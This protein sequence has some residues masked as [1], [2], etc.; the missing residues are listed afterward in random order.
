MLILL[1]NIKTEKGPFI[2]NCTD[3]TRRNGFKLKKGEF[4]L[5]I[6]KKFLNLRVMRHWNRLLD[7]VV[8]FKSL[9]MFKAM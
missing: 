3:R 2:R 5:N 7:E 8:D 9:A 4:R 1:K 6:G